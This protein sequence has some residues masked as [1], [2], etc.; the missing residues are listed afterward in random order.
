[1]STV[2]Q[3]LAN[4]LD[5]NSNG[6]CLPCMPYVN[7]QQGEPMTCPSGE[8]LST[9][10]NYRRRNEPLAGCE[11]NYFDAACTDYTI[12]DLPHLYLSKWGEDYKSWKCSQGDCPPTNYDYRKGLWRTDR[13][14]IEHAYLYKGAPGTPLGVPSPMNTMFQD[15]MYDGKDPSVVEAFMGCGNQGTTF[16]IMAIL[17]LAYLLYDRY[18]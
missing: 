14:R 6:D 7:S 13:E 9:Y 3:I 8:P 12:P 2:P 10:Y 17:L 15:T 5:T 18:N 4:A 11:L 1:M 16:I